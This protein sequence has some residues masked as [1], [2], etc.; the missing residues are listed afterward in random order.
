[1]LIQV[2]SFDFIAHPLVQITE[3]FFQLEKLREEPMKRET[4]DYD[5]SRR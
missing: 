2:A 5:N 3:K 1:M 4:Y